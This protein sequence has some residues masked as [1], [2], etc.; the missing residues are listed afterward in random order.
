[1]KNFIFTMLIMPT[2]AAAQIATP[3]SITTH[4]LDEVTVAATNQYALASKIVY[5]PKSNQRNSASD[6]IQL[7]SR[8]NIPQLDVNPISE[9]VKTIDNQG[10]SLF[11]NS[12]PATAEDVRGLNPTDVKRVEYMDYPT[13]PRFM[14][15]Q[16]VINFITT[17][18]TYGGYTKLS[19]KERLGINSGD[20]SIYSKFAYHRM[21]YDIMSNGKYDFNSHIG[22]RSTELYKFDSGTITRHSSTMS[23]RHRETGLYAGLRATWNKSDRFTLR[24]TLTLRHNKA[25]KNST[26]GIVSIENTVTNAE[27]H[28]SAP[29]ANS[30]LGWECEVFSTLGKGWSINGNVQAECRDNSTDNDYESSHS[31]ISNSASEDAWSLRENVQL[32]KTLSDKV[33]LFANITSGNDNAKIDYSGTS[34]AA[35]RFRQT[36]IGTYIGAS[37]TL[38]KISS[39]VDGG[40]AFESNSINGNRTDDR[41]PFTHVNLQYAPN[42]SNSLGVWFQYA[43]FSPDAS[44][45]NPNIIRESEMMCVGGNQDLKCSRHVSSSISYT[46]LHDN[47]WQLTAYATL[48][49]II[50]RQIA[51]YTPDGPDG[52]ML[53]KYHND[54]Y[55]NHG[56]IGARITG[57][58]GRLSASIAPR[59][60]LYKTT[61]LNQSVYNP[62]CCSINVNYYVGEI[63]LNGYWSSSWGYVDGDNSYKRRHPSEY[64]AGAGWSDNK[65]NVQLSLANVF[66]SSWKTSD[67]ALRTRWYD[68][69]MTQ[70]GADFH[71]RISL[72]ITYTLNYGKN[73]G[74]TNELTGDS[75]ISTSIL[76]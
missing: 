23:G 29:F 18:H 40:Y 19:G 37:L 61:G 38:N 3:D 2:M 45:K 5:I 12:H 15:T 26:T 54:G 24:N 13:D 43:T 21:E 33:G 17:I 25:S 56:Q 44:M 52:M 47:R 16:H 55:Y 20:A 42:M 53:K 9:S 4:D 75:N 60:L 50:N 67:D 14:R 71:R 10:V 41:Y 31:I 62:L 36:F 57:N 66:R 35:N 11:I 46:K 39:S 68:V 73:V 74:K 30:A 51:V 72:S 28:A 1:M 32:N 76:K 7:L 49:R 22:R 27:F 59:I 63:Y 34:N 6:G 64:S 65:W 8:M 70:F 48:F 58:L 69:R